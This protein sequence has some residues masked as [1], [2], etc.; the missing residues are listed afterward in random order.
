MSNACSINQ[1]KPTDVQKMVSEGKKIQL[2][3]VRTALEFDSEHI[4]SSKNIPLDELANRGGEIKKDCL[5]ILI[6]RTGNRASRAAELL[7][8][9]GQ[10]VSVMSGGITDWKKVKLALVEGKKRLSL[11]RQVQLTIGLL[12]LSSVALGWTV[13]KLWFVL[14]AFIGAGLTFAGLTGNC[15]LAIALS[16]APWNKVDSKPGTDHKNSTSCCS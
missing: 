3:D 7:S 4:D 13:D 14:P 12:L 10:E 15:G 16:K 11:E 6:C 1:I 2:V 8:S 9:Y 5:T